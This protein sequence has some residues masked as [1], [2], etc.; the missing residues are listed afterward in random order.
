VILGDELNV[1]VTRTASAGLAAKGV[2]AAPR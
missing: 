1:D 2:V